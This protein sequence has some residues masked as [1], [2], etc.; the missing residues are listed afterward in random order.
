[1]W[2]EFIGE[3]DPSTVGY[4][5]FLLFALGTDQHGSCGFGPDGSPVCGL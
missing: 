3:P 4:R 1:M 2:L 5:L